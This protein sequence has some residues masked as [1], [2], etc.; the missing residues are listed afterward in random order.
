MCDYCY[1]DIVTDLSFLE[2]LDSEEATAVNKIF[3]DIQTNDPP[4]PDWNDEVKDIQ[5]WVQRVYETLA[6]LYDLMV[7]HETRSGG[8]EGTTFANHYLTYQEFSQYCKYAQPDFTKNWAFEDKSDW[9]SACIKKGIVQCYKYSTKFFKYD[10]NNRAHKYISILT[11]SRKYRLWYAFWNGE[12]RQVNVKVTAD[13]YWSQNT[14]SIL[15]RVF[16]TFTTINL[17]ASASPRNFGNMGSSKDISSNI[18]TASSNPFEVLLNRRLR[19][20]V[21]YELLV[22]HGLPFVR[23]ADGNIKA[24]QLLGLGSDSVIFKVHP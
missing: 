13:Y 4:N 21:M 5:P 7:I 12:Q 22:E 18:S 23:T 14:L 3:N 16:K 1:E 20:K 6:Q 24:T 15:A 11:D 10:E 2:T 9:G 17:R 19:T 8:Q